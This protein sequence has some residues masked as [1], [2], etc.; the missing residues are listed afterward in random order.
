MGKRGKFFAACHVAEFA[1]SLSQIAFMSLL[2]GNVKGIAVLINKVYCTPLEN[3]IKNISGHYFPT[4]MHRTWPR[5]GKR[6]SRGKI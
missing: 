2:G 4:Y 6:G 3:T 1:A 5:N